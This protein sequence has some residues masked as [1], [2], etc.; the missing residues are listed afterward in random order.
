MARTMMIENKISDRFWKEAVHTTIHIQNRYLL[1]LHENKTPYELWFGRKAI[2]RHFKIFGSKCYIRNTKDS[3]SKFEDRAN[4]RIFL[5]YS[6]KSKA[7]QCYNKRLG[8]VMESVDVKVDERNAEI[9]NDYYDYPMYEENEK[10]QSP[11]PSPKSSSSASPKTSLPTS[12]KISPQETPKS[13]P[14]SSPKSFRKCFQLNHPSQQIIGD[15]NMG[16]Q[17]RRKVAQTQEHINHALLSHFEPK[18]IIEASKDES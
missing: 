7:Y 2:V 8:K 12:P 15:P 14:P 3:L 5:G 9:S 13:S 4:E 17:T 18:N 10:E 11:P 1:R 6:C 16:I